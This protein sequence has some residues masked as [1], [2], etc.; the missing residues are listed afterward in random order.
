[1]QFIFVGVDRV[2]TTELRASL[3]QRHVDYFDQHRH[4]IVL[5]GALR[6]GS[7]P[8]PAGSFVL[9]EA[10]SES[11]AKTFFDLEP[12][13]ENGLFAEKKM[14]QFTKGMALI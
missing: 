2:G 14:F 8:S 1:M 7:N 13:C 12:Y 6:D 4:R 9:I 3:K 5:S 10:D 11:E